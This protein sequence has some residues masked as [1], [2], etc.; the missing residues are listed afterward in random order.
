MSGFAVLHRAQSS[1]ETFGGAE[2]V[3]GNR[4]A[5]GEEG[6]GYAQAEHGGQ[7]C[8]GEGNGALA[9]AWP[10]GRVVRG[11]PAVCA[12]RRRHAG[13][14]GCCW[15]GCRPL[16]SRS[17]PN[18]PQCLNRDHQC[19][20]GDH[21]QRR[22]RLEHRHH[23][24]AYPRLNPAGHQLFTSQ[25][26]RGGVRG[27][28][29]VALGDGESVVAIGF[30]LDDPV[31]DEWLVGSP[32]DHD[33]ANTDGVALSGF[34]DDEASGWCGFP[35]GT[36]EDDHRSITQHQSDHDHHHG[37]QGGGGQCHNQS[38]GDPSDHGRGPSCAL[39]C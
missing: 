35:H 33:V 15:S 3:A 34:G 4:V 24:V 22:T 1:V 8:G 18:P 7:R 31:G 39:R 5:G 13:C 21:G 38:G 32:H 19:G 14:L 16:G 6:P 36:G 23:P 25:R 28:V 10:A 2:S 17:G 37:G 12:V 11:R 30:H 26:V 20:Q 27:F 9:S 29:G